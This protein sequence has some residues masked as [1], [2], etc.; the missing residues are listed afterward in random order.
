MISKKIKFLLV[1]LMVV[2]PV[3]L[4]CSSGDDE[5][6]L[7]Y[8]GSCSA[9]PDFDFCTDFYGEGGDLTTDYCAPYTASKEKCTGNQVASCKYKDE[10][11]NDAEDRFFGDTNDNIFRSLLGLA[12]VGCEAEEG[13]TWEGELGNDPVDPDFDDMPLIYRGTCDA[14]ATRD[15]CFDVYGE[16]GPLTNECGEVPS[17]TTMCTGSEAG[18]CIYQDDDG[19]DVVFRFFSSDTAIITEFEATCT[20]ERGSGEGALGGTWTPAGG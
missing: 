17:S 15:S 13:G 6:G 8:R 18:T 20:A 12:R 1:L 9:R 4:G 16:G 19:G 2:L 14:T 5:D 3:G 11:G 7:T 10:N